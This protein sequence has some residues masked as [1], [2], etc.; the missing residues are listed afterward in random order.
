[1]FLKSL[2]VCIGSF[3]LGALVCLFLGGWALSF[4][5]VDFIHQAAL[6]TPPPSVNVNLHEITLL[7]LEY[8]K[9]L[10]AAD[11]LEKQV[12]QL[13]PPPLQDIICHKKTVATPSAA[14]ASDASDSE[15][16]EVAVPRTYH[17]EKYFKQ[18]GASAARDP[19][20]LLRLEE[21][22]LLSRIFPSSMR[23]LF[24]ETAHFSSSPQT[25]ISQ[26]VLAL[27]LQI[28]IYREA[29]QLALQWEDLETKVESL[30]QLRIQARQC[31]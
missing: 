2:F 11:E 9:E 31:H 13:N 3:I 16:S 15:V 14:E 7:S 21:V 25:V 30:K 24:Q 22:K 6:P 17:L 12:S 19:W 4:Y 20:F 23:E 18:A 8:I 10:N 26:A 5:A 28:T 1:M 29:A 27:R